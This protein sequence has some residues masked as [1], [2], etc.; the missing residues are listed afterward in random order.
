LVAT[1]DGKAAII[2]AVSEDLAAQHSAV[3]LVRRAASAVGG[4][5]GGGSKTMAQAGG[6][7]GRHWQAALDAVRGAIAA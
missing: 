5:G 2:T 4:A 3:E 6:P 1:N 7:E